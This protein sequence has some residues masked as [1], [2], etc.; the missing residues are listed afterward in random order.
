MKTIDGIDHHGIEQPYQGKEDDLQKACARY[1]ALHPAKPLFFHVPNG[2][3]RNKIEGAKFKMMGVRPGV[4]DLIILEPRQGHF[5]SYGY[6]IELKSKGGRLHSS[7]HSFLTDAFVKGY[8]VAVCWNFDSF[9][10]VV[11]KYLE[12]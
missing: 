7:Q 1:L 4:S 9:K 10:A 8:N 5:V 6:M 12:K 2:G 11:D 3:A